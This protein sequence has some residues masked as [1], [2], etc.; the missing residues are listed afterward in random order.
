[1]AT[2]YQKEY[3]FAKEW[4]SVTTICGQLEKPYLYSWYGKLGWEAASTI[5]KNSKK[6]GALIDQEICHYFGD[7]PDE[8]GKIIKE[9]RVLIN[10]DAQS[11]EYYLSSVNNFHIFVDKYKPKSVL[12]QKVVYSKTHEYIGTLDRLLIVDGKLALVD[13]KATNSL[14]YEYKMQLEAY[15]RALTE[16]VDTGILVVDTKKWHKEALWL[17]QLPK[18][19]AIDLDKN[20]VKFESSDKRFDN[21]K[22]LLKFYY[23]KREEEKEYAEK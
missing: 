12:G 4:V 17:V 10:T 19:E 22:A 21:F 7:E 15:Y 5:N 14:S 13:W 23:G 18:K 8:D 1:M 9:A 2:R 16:M 20:V 6:I 11:K 3:P